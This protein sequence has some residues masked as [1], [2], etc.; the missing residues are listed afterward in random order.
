MKL[1]ALNIGNYTI[2]GPAHSGGLVDIENASIGQ[3]I[4]AAIPFVFAF[5]GI[6]LL[7]MIIASGFSLMTSAGDPKKMQM[8]R[9]RLTNALIGFL[10]IFA[11]YW[12]VQ[13]AFIVFGWNGNSV[14]NIFQ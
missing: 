12:I 6:G 7:L 11:A 10:L 4:N 8:G 3:I 1:L 5:A 14:Q 13:I 2:T 9:A